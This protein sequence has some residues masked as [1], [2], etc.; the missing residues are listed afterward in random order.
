M[1]AKC[2]VKGGKVKGPGGP[3]DD[4]ISAKLSN[5]E[6]VLP[7]DTV[8]A[9]G[10]NKLDMLKRATHTP[11]H[12]FDGGAVLNRIVDRNT[13]SLQA[14]TAD[15]SN[16]NNTLNANSVGEA[17]LTAGLIDAG[18][19]YARRQQNSFSDTS[20][21][22]PKPSTPIAP[23]VTPPATNASGPAPNTVAAPGKVNP[24]EAITTLRNLTTGMAGAPLAVTPPTPAPKDVVNGGFFH[25]P[26]QY[27]DGGSVADWLSDHTGGLIGTNSNVLATRRRT[28]EILNGT[29]KDVIEPEPAPSPAPAQAAQQP[30]EGPGLTGL[31]DVIRQRHELLHNMADGGRV[32][33]DFEAMMRAAKERPPLAFEGG[34]PG[35]P[36]TSTLELVPKGSEGIPY[37]PV[38]QRVP[39][40]EGFQLQP[41][42]L[43]TYPV[44]ELPAE[45]IIAK[46]LPG[47]DMVP[48][49]GPI[50]RM[51]RAGGLP[52]TNLVPAGE[53]YTPNLPV[54]VGSRSEPLTRQQYYE[55]SYG[56]PAS[57]APITARGLPP[58][59]AGGLKVAGGVGTATDVLGRAI[60]E[61]AFIKDAQGQWHKNPQWTGKNWLGLG[62]ESA[63]K[64]AAAYGGAKLGAGIGTFLAPEVPII[65]QV[66]GGGLG[67]LGGALVGE[68]GI[69][70][71]KDNYGNAVDW[72][73]RNAVEPTMKFFG[74]EAVS[75]AARKAGANK[76]LPVPANNQA[77]QIVQG[78]IPSLVTPSGETT[79]GSV[80][81][82][83]GPNGEVQKFVGGQ[84]QPVKQLQIAP[85]AIGEDHKP[86]DMTG[87]TMAKMNAHTRGMEALKAGGDYQAAYNEYLNPQARPAGVPMM[88]NGL[89][90]LQSA[91]Q[92]TL[93]KMQN[94]PLGDL[95]SVREF[96]RLKNVAALQGNMLEQAQAQQSGILERMYGAQGQA[97]AARINAA[98]ELEKQRMA[99]Q[100]ALNV[101]G[102]NLAGK[103]AIKIDPNAIKQSVLGPNATA[104]NSAY[105]EL[106]TA[107]ASG[108]QE[109]ATKARA[110]MTAALA[111]LKAASESLGTAPNIFN[112]AG[113]GTE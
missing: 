68:E 77:S 55:S 104:Y 45:H 13:A 17:G 75:D 37:T 30:A 99:G 72:I 96:R 42:T 31:P 44:E 32:Y 87:D 54:P 50:P 6:Y 18:N 56:K 102:L 26:Q 38:P 43:P 52:G 98:T 41:K 90:A 62:A 92:G 27:A 69:Q 4:K 101:A 33:S 63:G 86:V 7:A 3:T 111:E 74:D 85:T 109:A 110:K 28:E 100:S 15:L 51:E 25:H 36:A 1:N 58:G 106:Q 60:D 22:L 64:L 67:M 94:L 71:V 16:P 83:V 103:P 73:S 61:G 81:Y 82:T 35:P 65:P 21:G 24:N 12:M 113:V 76:G 2:M 107:V 66:I 108:N 9:V 88:G 70:A 11:V 47:T 34:L 112:M 80:R 93:A 29:A 105:R 78:S 48:A 39:T 91:Y 5:G 53:T 49:G 95:Q 97:N 46:G 19:Q 23:A 20:A 59:L 10:V 84:E 57:S 8:K 79:S 89:A 40:G 14:G